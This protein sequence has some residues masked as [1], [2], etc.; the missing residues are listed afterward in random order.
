MGCNYYA[1]KHYVAQ[2]NVYLYSMWMDFL[3][4]LD[5][6]RRL[7]SLCDAKEGGLA[8]IYGRRRIGKSRLLVQWR[9]EHSGV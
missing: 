8:V 4:R 9:D 1:Y 6:L 2:H 7:D 3:D 5:E